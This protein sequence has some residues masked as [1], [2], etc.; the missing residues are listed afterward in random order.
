[1]HKR[2]LRLLFCAFLVGV[3]S[4]GAL[5]YAFAAQYT[6]VDYEVELSK[7]SSQ[8]ETSALDDAY[9]L[10]STQVNYQKTATG[11]PGRY[12]SFVV[13]QAEWTDKAKGKLKLTYRGAYREDP[14][15]VD[16][17]LYVFTVC[18][19]HGLEVETVRKNIQQLVRLCDKCVCIGIDSSGIPREK[20]FD[21]KNIGSD[22]SGYLYVFDR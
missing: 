1:M 6:Y 12:D 20:S 19:A 13:S 18:T 14:E 4:F 8:K 15:A 11:T 3:T 9:A 22:L 16:A 21:T 7:H 5:P 17:P 10:T 2:L